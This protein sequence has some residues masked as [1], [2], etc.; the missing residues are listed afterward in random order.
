MIPS[1]K[2]KNFVFAIPFQNKADNDRFKI[3]R[4][5]E[6]WRNLRNLSLF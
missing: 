1:K 4:N 5:T 2:G 6:K 3:K